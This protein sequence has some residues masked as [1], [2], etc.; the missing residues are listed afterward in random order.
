MCKNKKLTTMRRSS[1]LVTSIIVLVISFILINAC[2]VENNNND[3]LKKVL[4][5]LNQIKSATY[6]RY[7]STT[8]P[9]DTVVSKSYNCYIKE[10]N[11]PAD[12]FVG[13]SFAEFL[14]GD[15]TKMANFYD[16]KVKSHLDWENRKIPVDSFQNNRFPY[17][18]VYPPFFTYVK[19]LIRYA[20][21]TSDSIKIELKDFGDSI[22]A[23]LSIKDKMVEVVGNRI[24]YADHSGFIDERYTIYDI[25]INKTTGLPYRLRKKLPSG[26]TWETTKNLYVNKTDSELFMASKY[27]PPDFIITQK[28]K[29][30]PNSTNLEGQIAPDWILKAGDNS[31]IAFN[32][33]KNKILLIQFTGIGCGPCH[34]SIPFLKQLVVDYKGK[35]FEFVSI[36]TWSKN[37]EELKRYKEK[38]GLN[39][40]FLKAEESVTNDYKVNSVPMFFIIDK[41]RVIRKVIFGY[42]KDVTDTEILNEI[43]KLI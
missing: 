9:Y 19:S 37:I 39:F 11:N 3:Y 14:L 33:L 7:M 40:K 38:N 23:I 10:F 26:I 22:Q 30:I 42:S 29:A 25:W 24:V 34:A 2:K 1:L 13:A 15:S 20:L 5:N 36:E 35:N 8:A 31:T 17:R 16:G 12:T 6:F 18:V 28:G 21:E 32:D 4:N 41:N 43:N 27:F